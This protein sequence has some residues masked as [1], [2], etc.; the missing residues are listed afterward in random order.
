MKYAVAKRTQ[1]FTLPKQWA[2][3]RAAQGMEAATGRK[4][5]HLEKGDYQ[6]EEF[7]LP[8]HVAAAAY[9]GLRDGDVRY[10]PGPGL[11]ELREAIAAE[12]SARG[13]PT[14]PEEVVV[15]AGAKHSLQIALLTLL[16][17]GDGLIFPNPGYPPDEVWANYAG[18]RVMH[19]PL[20]PGSWQ[21]DLGSLARLLEG[22]DVKCLV[23]N[24]PQRPNGELVTDIE[25]IAR[26]VRPRRGLVTLSDEIFS[27][28]VY[29]DKR[30]VSISAVAG[31]ADRTILIDTF[32]KTYAMTGWRIGWTVAPAPLAQRFSMFLQDSITNVATFVQRAALAAMTG[33]QDWVE[34]KLMRLQRKRNA[35][36]SGLNSIA[37]IRCPTPSGSFYVFADISQTGLSAEE[38]TRR[39]LHEQQIAVVAGTAFGS[40][41]Q[42]FVRLTFAVPDQDIERGV[43]GI[44][45]MLGG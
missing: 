4:V 43:A 14:L 40:Q 23:I 21:Y 30:H 20:T 36:V 39:L 41:G 22:D 7:R 27:H 6:G 44:A 35:M 33:P 17:E 28:I 10:D 34:E 19:T 45:A 37:G 24:T 13:R 11:P 5:I 12:V 25:E 32:S 15:T 16:D 9:D 38:F 8:P 1:H 42:G 26:L 18:A 2:S 3:M 31:M 29:D